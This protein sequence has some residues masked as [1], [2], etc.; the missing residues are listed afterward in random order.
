MSELGSS[1]AVGIESVEWLDA[2]GGQLTV[3]VTG[4]WRR[5]R[6][7]VESRG[8]TML[9]IE[10]EGRRHRFPATPEPPSLSGAA[11][12]TWRLSFSVPAELAHGL[13]GHVW[14]ALGTVTVPLPV[15][16]SAAGA[17]AETETDEAPPIR[18]ERSAPAEP[19]GHDAPPGGA[20]QSGGAGVAK[21]RSERG[22]GSLEIERAWRR[23]DAAE[24]AADE[25]GERVSALE[26]ALQH[27]RAERA[28]LRARPEP[29][30]EAPGRTVPAGDEQQRLRAEDA[31]RA[32]RRAVG[33]R[34]PSEPVAPPAG[35]ASLDTSPAGL[36]ALGT[37]PAGPASLDTSPAGSAA[38]G[39][40]A[41][42]A[43]ATGESPDWP[44][45]GED[46]TISVLRREL[47]ARAAAEAALHARAVQAET[48]LAARVLLEQRTT[49]ALAEL[50]TEL[51]CLGEALERE[52]R[53]RREAEATAAR[54][55]AEL[56]GQRERSRDAHAAIEEL[57]A[58]IEQLRPQA[59]EPPPAAGGVVTPDR[60]SDALTRLRESA[61]P[62]EA[63]EDP[64]APTAPGTSAAPVGAPTV[65]EPF[66]RLAAR[67]P[68]RA[69][70]LVIGLLGAQRAAWPHPV[71][72]DLVLGPGYGCVLV[73]AGERGVSVERS[74]APRAR[75]QVV[76]QIVGGPAPLA[77]LLRAGPL[78]RLLRIGLARVRGRR[79]GLSALRA[80]LALPLDIGALQAAGAA[81]DGETLFT[82]LA[83]MIDPAWTRGERFTIS[84][85]DARGH[86]V[87]LEICDG[88]PAL[89]ALEPPDGR[90][91]TA[92][93]GPP[94]R[95]WQMFAEGAVEPGT[96]AAGV[97]VTGDQGPLTLVRTW[98]NRAQSGH[99]AH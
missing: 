79:E 93:S 85:T 17:A 69:G 49:A 98:A 63:G 86:A 46:D 57:R 72:Y 99:G 62:R 18:S 30:P 42:A 4:R 65:E 36:A 53:R 75:E 20:E 78:R 34:I 28:R 40:A 73:T 89:V 45:A 94:E 44:L 5:R 1:A 15:P 7:W 27:E 67:D 61:Q 33:P 56:G 55:R 10:A 96:G 47:R 22:S 88:R 38:L 60:L 81:A 2:G 92:L 48:R 43:S 68:E 39:S 6:G 87:F 3:R 25:L 12:G 70:R 95:L 11:P 32:A 64:P 54:L 51:K 13:G 66:R 23:A 9:V 26:R 90:I 50:R 19:T 74:A 31:L 8:P 24:R 83:A 14:L 16:E 52:R 41:S 82:L 58:A 80:L 84:H 97:R 37:S 91:A 71:A 35:A 29:L 76:V 59:P 77:R 21:A